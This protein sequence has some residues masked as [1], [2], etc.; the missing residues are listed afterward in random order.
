MTAYSFEENADYILVTQKKETNNPKN[1]VTEF[2]DYQISVD[3]AK[4]ICMRDWKSVK[5]LICSKMSGFK[6]S[7]AERFSRMC[8]YGFFD[9]MD[10]LEVIVKND[11]NSKDGRPATDLYDYFGSDEMTSVLTPPEVQNNGGVQIRELQDY[12]VSVDT[13][14]HICLISRTEKGKQWSDH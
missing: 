4:Q 5:I 7:G 12:I 2:T 14:K 10:Y 9:K 13:A 1:P 3:M 11:E 6:L 8:E